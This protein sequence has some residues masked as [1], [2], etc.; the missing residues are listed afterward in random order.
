LFKQINDPAIAANTLGIPYPFPYEEVLPYIER[1]LERAA[2]GEY[3]PF[4]IVLKDHEVFIG[5][6]RLTTEGDQRRAELAYWLGQS[7]WGRGY[8]TEA[9]AHVVAFGFERLN[10]NRI[11]AF[12]FADN[13]GSRRVME[14]LGMTYEGTWRRDVLKDGQFK[15]VAFYGLLRTD[16]LKTK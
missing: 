10:I 15:D 8:V 14:K 1:N 4:A 6:T 12:C 16:Y 3:A 5:Y 7:Y 11:F 9:A 13:T 2:T